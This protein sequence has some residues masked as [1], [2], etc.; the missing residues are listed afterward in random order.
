MH[1]TIK[2]LDDCDKNKPLKNNIKRKNNN[3]TPPII[4]ISKK[5]CN[6][7]LWGWFNKVPKSSLR[8]NSMLY[9]PNPKG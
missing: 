7:I 1:T 2:T 8:N 4:P 9:T 5:N 6:I 3:D